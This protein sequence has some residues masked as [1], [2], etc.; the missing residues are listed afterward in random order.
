MKLLDDKKAELESI[1]KE[2]IKGY[3]TRARIQWL[4]Q[5]E[6]PTSFFCKLESKQFTEKTIRKL[7]LDNGFIINDQKMIL[8]EVQKYYTNLFKEKETFSDFNLAKNITG[9]KVNQKND[10][11]K[12]ISVMELGAVLKKNEKQQISWDRW[13]VIRIFQSILG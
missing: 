8:K 2:K 3:I 12:N 9:N 10:I 13:P 5:G 11:G 6:K 7:Q 1:R 4:D